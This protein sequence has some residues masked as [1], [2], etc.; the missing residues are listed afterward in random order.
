M[1][2]KFT[3]LN[4]SL[5]AMSAL[6]LLAS[7]FIDDEY[8]VEIKQEEAQAKINAILPIKMSK[9]GIDVSVNT[10]LMSFQKDNKVLIESDFSA[11][12][13]GES[14]DGKG[15]AVTSVD[16]VSG[17]IFLKDPV[18]KSFNSS[19]NESG[20]IDDKKSVAIGVWNKFKSKVINTEDTHVNKALERIKD[21]QVAKI[22]IM[23]ID[24]LKKKIDETPIYSLNGKDLKHSVAA[25]ALKEIK[26][27]DKYLSVKL[28]VVKFL[29]SLAIKILSMFLAICAVISIC[30][31]GPRAMVGAAL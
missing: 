18:L 13:F 26:F 14:V 28:S 31:F 5:L 16:Y 7:F 10:M 24:T 1:R 27:H 30:F 20:S 23:L 8:T 17:D 22:K 3:V 2:F 4:S 9:F 6:I 12:G 11:S 15:V 29:S 25:M 21:S 19:F